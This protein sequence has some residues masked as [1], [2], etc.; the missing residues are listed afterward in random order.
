VSLVFKE[1]RRVLLSTRRELVLSLLQDG[2]WHSTSGINHP[3]VGGSEGTR[4]LR[5]LRELGYPIEKHRR[6]GHDDY[7]YRLVSIVEM[8]RSRRRNPP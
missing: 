5:E 8:V 3:A 4:R 2:E 6:E 1:D 7:E